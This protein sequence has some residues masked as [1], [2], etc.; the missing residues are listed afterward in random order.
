MAVP[1]Q[2][3]L[4]GLAIGAATVWYDFTSWK[5]FGTG[6][7][8]PT[9]K[10][11]LKIRRWGLW[12]F[13]HSQDL[14]NASAIPDEGL[15]YLSK[16]DI[17]VRAGPRPKLTRWTLPQR[18]FRDPITPTAAEALLNM[19]PSTATSFP[20]TIRSGPSKTEG[21]TGPAIYVQPS[22]PTINPVAHKIFYEVAHVHP[23]ENS[24]HVYVSPRDART[25]VQA[26]WGQRFPVTWLAPPSWI[27][28]YA[29]RNEEEVEVVEKIV[30]AAAMFAVG[31]NLK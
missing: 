12:L 5:A 13:F 2:L 10:G 7:T 3:A 26:G 28:V 20:Q 24:L 16:D 8:P 4:V 23:A 30:K 29:P 9:L 6:G 18:Q 21:G 22:C 11:Y 27:M 14:L 17:P 15:A 31:G 1:F 19:M 25:V